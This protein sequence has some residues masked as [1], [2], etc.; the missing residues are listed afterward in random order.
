MKYHAHFKRVP[1][2]CCGQC[3]ATKSRYKSI[4]MRLHMLFN[5]SESLGIVFFFF[6][7]DESNVDK[8]H[9]H[10]VH[11]ELLCLTNDCPFFQF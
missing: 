11:V 2:S 1:C 7:L 8:G 9:N 4:K 10:I 5:P 6:H 3:S